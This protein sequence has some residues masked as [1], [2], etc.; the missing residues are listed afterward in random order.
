MPNLQE[1]TAIKGLLAKQSEAIQKRD[2]AG[3]TAN[4]KEN[5]I[6]FDVVGPLQHTGASSVKQRL[7]EWFGTFRDNDPIAFE[8]KELSVKADTAIAFSHGFNHISAALKNGKRLDMYWRETLNWEKTNGKWQ[9]VSAHS[10][11]PFDAG[12]GMAST[13]LKPGEE[14][15]P[16]K[17]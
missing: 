4:Y 6:L 10:S 14:E 13:G 9:I 17:D 1:E 15:P 2:I 8:T 12:T 11:V 16:R 5:V 7:Q 3:A